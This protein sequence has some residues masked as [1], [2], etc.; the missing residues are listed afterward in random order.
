MTSQ[1]SL[2]S[3][4]KSA[5]G[6]QKNCLLL[7]TGNT[8]QNNHNLTFKKCIT[9]LVMITVSEMHDWLIVGKQ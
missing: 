5:V 7:S 3:L 2:G 6:T 9:G 1:C 4:D 8:C